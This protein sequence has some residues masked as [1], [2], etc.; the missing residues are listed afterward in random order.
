MKKRRKSNKV[1]STRSRSKY[2]K[3]KKSKL[4]QLSNKSPKHKTLPLRSLRN[5]KKKTNHLR[6]SFLNLKLQ[7]VVKGIKV[8]N[9]MYRDFQQFRVKTKYKKCKDL[10]RRSQLKLRK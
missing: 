3:R 7:L 10:S 5:Q 6:L 9:K 8:S 4:L 2:L 1:K